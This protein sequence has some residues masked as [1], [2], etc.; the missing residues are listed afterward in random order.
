MNQT[1]I[2]LPEKGNFSPGDEV[3]IVGK[4]GNEE[5]TL[6]EVAGKMETIAKNSS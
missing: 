3:I 5:I 4:Q 1:V 6:E 2:L